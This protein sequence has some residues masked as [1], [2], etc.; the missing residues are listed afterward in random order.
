[1]RRLPRIAV[2]MLLLVTSVAAARAA[3]PVIERVDVESFRRGQTLGVRVSDADGAGDLAS[4]TIVNPLGRVTTITPGV[5][6]AVQWLVE[7]PNTIL[8][9]QSEPDYEAEGLS[10]LITAA[11]AG[12][13]EDS[14]SASFPPPVPE[15]PPEIMYPDPN[16][17]L[18]FETIPTFAWSGTQ[19][20]AE[21][22]LVVRRAHGI[23]TALW[24]Y[25]AGDALS[26]V[27]DADGMAAQPELI[28]GYTYEVELT[29]RL[30]VDCGLTDPR[31]YV[32]TVDHAEGTFIVYSEAPV[33]EGVGLYRV[34]RS[35]G[36]AW[37]LHVEDV[38]AGVTDGNGA[39]DIVSVT[40]TY[41][42]G[43]EYTLTPTSDYWAEDGP[44]SVT[45][46]RAN[47]IY[48]PEEHPPVGTYTLTA[49]DAA[50]HE[51]VKATPW[52]DLWPELQLL[53]PVPDSVIE[54]SQPTLDWETGTGNPNTTV[55]VYEEGRG[56]P[57][58]SEELRGETETVYN[59]N[60]Y[61]EVPELRPGRTYVCELRAG[62][63]D[64][65]TGDPEVNMFILQITGT[66][67]T[68][69]DPRPALPAL[70][71]RLAYTTVLLTGVYGSHSSW[72][73]VLLYDPDPEVRPWLGPLRAWNP[74]LSPDA[75]RLVY[76]RDGEIFID[77]LDGGPPVAIP[78][79]IGK[80]TRWAPDG[81]QIVYATLEENSDIW[82]TDLMGAA[83]YP[84]IVEPLVQDRYPAWSPD[85]EWILYRR[86]PDDVGQGLWIVR[87]D[88]TDARPVL[89]T[90]VEGYP[91]HQ[92]TDIGEASWSPSSDQIACNFALVP[93]VG[94]A[95]WGIGVIPREG[96][97]VSPIFLAPPGVVC[98]AGP[99]F[100]S[101]SPDGT[102]IAFGSAHHLPIDE[103]WVW[104][105]YEPG[106]EVWVIDAH[107]SGEPVRLTYDY[108]FQRTI[109][110][111]Q[112]H[113]FS[114]VT[115][116]YWAASEIAAC[117][118]AGIVSGYPDGLYRPTNPLT[119][120]QMAVYI[121]RAL[122]GGDE[123]VPDGGR[124]RSFFDV[125]RGHWAFDHIEYCVDNGVVAGYRFAFYHPEDE[126]TRDQMAAYIARAM[127]APTGEAALAD[128]VPADPRN[129]P[130]VPSDSWAYKHVEYCVENGVV[131]GYLDGLYHPEI[132]V[133]RDQM[134][135]YVARAFGLL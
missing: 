103:D 3:A 129:F 71:G 83:P 112:G 8:A 32:T 110:W 85:G 128:Y 33:V 130:D 72:S 90:G 9:T 91:D 63:A 30:C 6:G 17:G 5:G 10:Y 43:T 120:D 19:A 133:T 42:D 12:G 82:I 38:G 78:A 117:V 101:W 18:I 60:G 59:W 98:C 4:V 99:H 51:G 61:A 104:G 95:I 123:N 11:D 53:T 70:P 100:P 96:G 34:I 56:W 25:N 57:V 88:G 48:M 118:G 111:R 47:R 29:S 31:V 55:A 115:R 132:V 131:A 20:G 106:S 97:M 108:S 69:L 24:D 23:G 93:P 75:Q 2:A 14:L 84:L 27:Y 92:V 28:P 114:D 74:D 46:F 26:A 79:Q 124:S 119:R 37:V 67:F 64:V 62:T 73:S 54:E 7:G 22:S 87:P 126:A 1:M 16:E 122:A 102:M 80:D 68:M 125:P 39:A 36:G 94:E 52:L 77:P 35:E 13:L 81:E 116:G 127:V 44:Y 121:A 135:V 66:R 58:W 86:V 15:F 89:A 40:I 107:G 45:A 109:T 50:G 41:P 113:I 49:R 134:A 65:D 105:K 21:N 76:S